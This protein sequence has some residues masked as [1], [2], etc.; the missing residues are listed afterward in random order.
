VQVVNGFVVVLGLARFAPPNA[1][2]EPTIFLDGAQVFPNGGAVNMASP[3]LSY[4]DMLNPDDISFIEVLTGPDAA[5]YGIRGANGVI[6]INSKNRNDDLGDNTLNSY[7]VRGYHI[8]PPFIMPDYGNAKM[9]A[10]KFNDMRSTLY[11]NP[12]GLTDQ[13]G[14]LKV[15]FFTSDIHAGYKVIIDGVTIRGDVIHK[16]IPFK[17]E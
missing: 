4:L 11:W 17:T 3:V 9:K 6:L 2:T 16:V 14:Q 10:A 1:S 7:L 5:S 12:L 8:P 15:V 13:Q